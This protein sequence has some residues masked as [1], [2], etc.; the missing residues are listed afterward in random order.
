MIAKTSTASSDTDE[1]SSGVLS[2][3]SDSGLP[4]QIDV[5]GGTPRGLEL[6]QPTTVQLRALTSLQNLPGGSLNVRYNGLTATPMS[7]GNSSGYLTAPNSAAPEQ[8]A[9]D[10]VRRWREV[11]RFDEND[12]TDLKLVSRATTQEGTTVMLFQQQAADLPRPDVQ[13]MVESYSTATGAGQG[14]VFDVQ[15]TTFSAVGG[16]GRSVR[17]GTNQ[18]NFQITRPTYDAE[19]VNTTNHFRYSLVLARNEVPLPFSLTSLPQPLTANL[20]GQ[21]LR[22]LP[23]AARPTESSPFGWFYLPTDTGGQQITTANNDHGTTQTLG[24]TMASE[25]R[26]RNLPANSP[27]GRRR[28]V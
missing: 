3:A 4:A 14:K 6:R 5:R 25:A 16:V 15:P 13:N 28:A 7:V 26:T 20:I 2:M 12:L 17:T 10:F 27:N 18:S 21:V 23:D 1:N 19:I 11:F 9:R 24:Y 22:G 8:I